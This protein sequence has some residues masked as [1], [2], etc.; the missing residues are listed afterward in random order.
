MTESSITVVLRQ[1]AGPGDSC[2]LAFHATSLYFQP[3]KGHLLLQVLLATTH[4]AAWKPNKGTSSVI[5]RAAT[6]QPQ[7]RLWEECTGTCAELQ[8]KGH[9]QPREVL[10]EQ[11]KLDSFV[12][13]RYTT[14]RKRFQQRLDC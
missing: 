9:T 3:L 5:C 6:P 2:W 11:R 12:T 7:C 14:V 4:L 8:P 13:K 10:A 1:N